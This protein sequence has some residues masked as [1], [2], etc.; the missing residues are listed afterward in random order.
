MAA[1]IWGWALRR[2]IV[3]YR[4]SSCRSPR[5]MIKGPMRELGRHFG[6]LFPFILH[7][8]VVAKLPLASVSREHGVWC[9]E[10]TQKVAGREAHAFTVPMTSECFHWDGQGVET[11]SV[12]QSCMIWG[13]RRLLSLED[14]SIGR[15]WELA[16]KSRS[17]G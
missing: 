12:G 15:G 17:E 1:K 10:R 3:V 6:Q 2:M 4:G 14:G 11:G 13:G 9:R 16:R 8:Q 7:H 5:T